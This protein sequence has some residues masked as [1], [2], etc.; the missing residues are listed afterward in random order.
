MRRH[1]PA[2]RVRCGVERI[3][4]AERACAIAAA[5][6]H[7]LNDELTVILT[8]VRST[9]LALEPGHPARP[10]LLDLQGAAQR[11]AWM[12]STLLNYSARKGVRPAPTRMERLVEID[13][14]V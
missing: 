4:K 12:A 5:A 10:M 13:A 1:P 14:L 8:S 6:A 2:R 3:L 11:C 9:M 7:E